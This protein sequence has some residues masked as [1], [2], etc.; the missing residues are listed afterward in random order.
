MI[1]SCLYKCS[2]PNV[3]Y[4]DWCKIRDKECIEDMCPVYREIKRMSS[5]H[6]DFKRFSSDGTHMRT[7]R[8]AVDCPRDGRWVAIQQCKEM[9]R[10]YNGYDYN[11]IYCKYNGEEAENDQ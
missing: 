1:P 8:N 7:I 11:H 10:F 4:Y 2:N 3:P 5:E 6:P 9:C